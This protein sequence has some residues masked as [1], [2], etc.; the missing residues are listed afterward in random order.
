MTSSSVRYRFHTEL[1]A[2]ELDR[3]IFSILRKEY[4]RSVKRMITFI[5][6]NFEDIIIENPHS[7][8]MILVNRLRSLEESKKVECTASGWRLR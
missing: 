2:D 6:R 3:I 8:S 5:D 7:L 4:P 1:T